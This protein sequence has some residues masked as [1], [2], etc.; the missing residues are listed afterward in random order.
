MKEWGKADIKAPLLVT[1]D[2]RC[3]DSLSHWEAYDDGLGAGLLVVV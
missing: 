1:G 3:R 2:P